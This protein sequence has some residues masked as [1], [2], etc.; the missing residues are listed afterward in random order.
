MK[1]TDRIR[2]LQIAFWWLS[3]L[4][5]MTAIFVMSS[6]PGDKKP[7]DPFPHA[8]KGEHFIVYGVLAFT[9]YGAIRSTAPNRRGMFHI[10]APLVIATL[11]ALSDE[12]H[13][14]FVPGRSKSIPDIWADFI[15]ALVVVSVMH[16]ANLVGGRNRE[17]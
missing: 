1:K 6:V 17:R 7:S 9:L 14:G 10:I 15:G 3:V 16:L 5:V 2:R 12:I 13:Q 11:Y 4:L 8:D